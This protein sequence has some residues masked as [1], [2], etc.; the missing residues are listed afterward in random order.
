VLGTGGFRLDNKLAEVP[1]VAQFL[2]KVGWRGALTEMA[3]REGELQWQQKKLGDGDAAI[4]ALLVGLGAMVKLEKL[5]LYGNQVGDEGM[6]SF[7][8]A[9]AS[10]SMGLLTVSPSLLPPPP[11]AYPHVPFASCTGSSLVQQQYWG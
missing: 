8:S 2:S 6:K 3:E 4:L 7:S 11:V 9:L 1:K 5:Y 10:G